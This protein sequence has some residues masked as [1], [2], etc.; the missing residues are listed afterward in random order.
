HP[1]RDKPPPGGIDGDAERLAGLA[2]VQAVTAEPYPV[3]GDDGA[4]IDQRAIVLF[5]ALPAA[6]QTGA[7]GIG[8]QRKLLDQQRKSRLGELRRLIAR[9][10]HDMDRVI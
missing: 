7:S 3:R 4:A 9:I 10:R 5:V 8:A 2:P 6:A 1:P